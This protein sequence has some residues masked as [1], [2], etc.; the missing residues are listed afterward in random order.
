MRVRDRRAKIVIEAERKGLFHKDGLWLTCG[1]RVV[2]PGWGE[3]AREDFK[4]ILLM[5]V[6]EIETG[7]KLDEFHLRWMKARRQYKRRQGSK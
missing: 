2:K 4:D 6:D 5:S 1:G 3:Y 7:I